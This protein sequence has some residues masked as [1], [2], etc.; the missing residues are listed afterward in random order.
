[1]RQTNGQ[2][3]GQAESR[4]ERGK[5]TKQMNMRQTNGQ[6]GRQA[7]RDGNRKNRGQTKEMDGQRDRTEI[8]N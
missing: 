5:H 7:D 3:G 8:W 2:T 1:M 6:T 4:I